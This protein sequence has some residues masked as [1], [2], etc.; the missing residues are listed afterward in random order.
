ML[1]TRDGDD[2]GYKT[3]GGYDFIGDPITSY[4]RYD[5]SYLG[6]IPFGHIAA[7]EIGHNIGFHHAVSE[8]SHGEECGGGCPEIW[9]FPHGL[10]GNG[11]TE[12]GAFVELFRSPEGPDDPGTYR[13]RVVDPC[14]GA[15]Y[16]ERTAGCPIRDDIPVPEN[17]QLLYGH[18]PHE[19]MSY[20]LST[21]DLTPLVPPEGELYGS[22]LP[23]YQKLW[24]S[25]VNYDRMFRAIRYS[26]AIYGGISSARPLAQASPRFASRQMVEAFLIAG[27]VSEDGTAAIRLSSIGPFWRARSRT[28]QAAPTF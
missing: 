26:E 12:F 5:G 13:L 3:L 14:P 15:T 10:M 24:P 11:N 21:Y 28:T 25:P 18:A 9:P 23:N 27:T 22:L 2:E 19:L 1:G 16:V 17:G 7:H 4:S 20:G 8:E 6:S